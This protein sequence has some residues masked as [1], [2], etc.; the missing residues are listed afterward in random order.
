MAPQQNSPPARPQLAVVVALLLLIAGA[1]IL[2]CWLVRT[3]PA[4][5]QAGAAS[6]DD[7]IA[8]VAAGRPGAVAR[9]RAAANADWPAGLAAVAAMLDHDNW[10]VRAAG[11][12]LLAARRDGTLLALILPRA[13]DADWRVREA[14]FGVLAPAP[15]D[16]PH[17][18]TPLAERE[19]VLLAWLAAR[20]EAAEPPLLPELCELYASARHV[21]FGR[22]LIARCLR[23]HAGTEP[24]PPAAQ[25]ACAKCHPAV[26]Q[27]WLASAHA[28]SLTHLHLTTIDPASRQ[29]KAVDFGEL[30]GIGCHE[31]HPP[32]LPAAERA[33]RP[34]GPSPVSLPADAPRGSCALKRSR[35]ADTAELCAPCHRHPYRQ[36][37]AWRAGDQPRRAI[38]PPGQLELHFRGD[39]RGCAD[40]HMPPGRTPTGPGGR[41]DHGW[42]ARRDHRLLAGGIDV[43]AEAEA[44]DGA[45]DKPGRS[46]RFVLTNLAGHDYPTGTRRRAVRLIVDRGAGAPVVLATLSP[47]RAGRRPDRFDPPLRP[48]EQRG[49]SWAAPPAAGTA[50]ISYRLVYLRDHAD[51][52]AYRIEIVSG[53]VHAPR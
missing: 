23:C 28:Q 10:R 4:S 38:W 2:L 44:V 11:C 47:D 35:P 20:D 15:S 46:A 29:A 7:C 12:E 19:R 9:A 41:R 34:S 49:L 14:A 30:R 26:H 48:G 21:E 18:N 16:R 24:K 5:T 33:G 22:P 50:P 25:Q 13:S 51:P 52:N 43:R 1:A 36:W 45:A 40:C 53:T 37:R 31:C 42:A 3:Q 27:Q 32:P 8:D 6:L 17:R 39:R